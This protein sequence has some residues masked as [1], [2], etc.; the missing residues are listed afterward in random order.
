MMA[1]DGR[2]M[3]KYGK[4]MAKYDGFRLGEKIHTG[5]QNLT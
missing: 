3:V 4:L 1:N 5:L 2:M